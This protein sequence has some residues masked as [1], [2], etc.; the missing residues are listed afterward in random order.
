MP[1][2]L[3]IFSVTIN[4][5][6]IK[7]SLEA[8]LAI[9]IVLLYL[10]YRNNRRIFKAIPLRKTSFIGAVDDGNRIKQESLSKL[11]SAELVVLQFLLQG[12][13]TVVDWDLI[14]LVKQ[15]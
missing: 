2:I 8:W 10:R 14:M 5:N 3:L 13:V 4:I 12:L 15:L 9:G 6:Y 11:L 7:W 1:F